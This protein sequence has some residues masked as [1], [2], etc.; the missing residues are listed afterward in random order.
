M[1][2][3]TDRRPLWIVASNILLDRVAPR[4]RPLFW[5]A[6]AVVQSLSL[7]SRLGWTAANEYQKSRFAHCGTGVRLHGRCRITAHGKVSLG[8]NVHIN[9]NAFIRAE[10]GLN[11]GD[12]V[13]ISRNLVLYTM[14]HNF[15]GSTLPYDQTHLEKPVSI[16]RNVWVGMNVLITPGVTIGDGAIIGMGTVVSR[17]VQ[18]LEIVGNAPQR[19]IRERDAEHY[20]DLEKRRLYGGMSGYPLK[21]RNRPPELS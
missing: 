10:G 17:D 5:P 14:N 20:H 16:G 4:I 6:Y 8:N 19:V 7:L 3:S 21:D 1:T 18:P 11:I 15:E 12:N 13:H 2:A 9:S